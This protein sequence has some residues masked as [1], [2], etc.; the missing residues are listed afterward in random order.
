MLTEV[1]EVKGPT[2]SREAKNNLAKFRQ[3]IVTVSEL[4]E[5][6]VVNALL[7]EAY[8]APSEL[9]MVQAL[10][11]RLAEGVR[12]ARIDAGSIDLLTQ[13]F[14]LDS[15]E[16]IALMCLAEAML[17][18]PDTDTRNRLIR[19]K[20]V[21]GDWRAHVGKSPSMFVNATAWGLLFTGKMLK[22]PD[23]SVLLESLS[24]VLRKGGEAVVRAGVSFAMLMLGKQFVTGETIEEAIRVAQER[25]ARGYCYSY[26]MLGEAALTREDAQAYYDAYWHAIEEIGKSAKQQG[27]I[28]GHGVSVKLTGLHPRYEMSQRERVI[29]EMYP[30]LLKL[31]CAAKQWNIGFHLD[32]EDAARFDLTLEMLERLACAP[33]LKGWDGLGISLQAY[34]K[35]GRAVVDWVIGLARANECKILVRLVK[36]A[37]W[38]TEIKR[39]QIEGTKEFP[40]FTRKVYSDVSYI[41]CAKRL[42]AA[43]DAVFP[44]FATHNAF[45]IA[46]IHT[47]GGDKEYEFQCLHGM[48]ET[49]YDQVVGDGKLG[50]RC[51]IYAPV[52]PHETLLAYLVRRLLENGANSSFVS[53]IVNP[54]ISIADIVE[55]PVARAARTAGRPHPH[56]VSPP[57]LLPGRKNAV[58]I[59]LAGSADFDA[60]LADLRAHRIIAEPLIGDGRNQQG[61]AARLIPNPSDQAEMLGSVSESNLDTLDAALEIAVGTGRAWAAR[62]LAE[63][64]Q[65]VAAVG[66]LLEKNSAR[67]SALLVLE[68]GKTLPDAAEEVRQAIG[69][70]RL[71]AH[72]AQTNSSLLHA[73]PLGAVVAISPLSS[74]L[75]VFVGQV[76]VA[77]IAGNAVLAKPS[78]SAVLIAFESVRLFHQAGIPAPA[79][80][81]LPGE[82]R[83]VG[84][85]LVRDHRVAA[86]LFS[87]SQAISREIGAALAVLPHAPIFVA[88]TGGFNSMIVDSSAL[89]EQVISDAICSAFDSAGQRASSLRLLCLQDSTAE[90]VLGMLQGMLRERVVGAPWT[91]STDIGP[92]V[93]KK[94]QNGCEAYVKRMADKGFPVWRAAVGADSKNGRFVAPAIIDL[95]HFDAIQEI[96]QHVMGPVLHVV[97]WKSGQL[98][99]LLTW[100]NENTCVLVQ[101]LHTRIN[102]TAGYVLSATRADN[103]YINR[104]MHTAAVG[105]QP[106]G[107]VGFAGTGPK[108]AGPLALSRLVKQSATCW[109]VDD[110]AFGRTVQRPSD[111]FNEIPVISDGKKLVA[112]IVHE[113]RVVEGRMALLKVIHDAAIQHDR[114][115]ADGK[116]RIA[117]NLEKLRNVISSGNAFGLPAP[118][119]EENT[120][121]FL[122]KGRA[123][124]LGTSEEGVVQQVLAAVSF[125]NQVLLPRSPIADVLSAI[126]GSEHCILVENNI[127]VSAEKVGKSEPQVIL[128]DFSGDHLSAFRERVI[129]ACNEMV[130]VIVPDNEGAYDWT[131][132]V[133]ERTIAIN[134]S[135]AGGNTQLMM[136]TE[137]AT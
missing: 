28:M 101:G 105:M 133:R 19:D 76:A 117:H 50:R 78:S 83:V 12:E 22:P 56:I 123:L 70:C 92:V 46:A 35:C 44:Q 40:V 91:S 48:G 38:D 110:G 97:R 87:G 13:E 84:S 99:S 54:E 136:L 24:R 135:A 85:A 47:L 37:Y 90:K 102:E 74:P 129:V 94:I 107:G 11:T 36:G 17:R 7:K 131:Y 59:N 63:R 77:L 81:F 41:A 128:T 49:V 108:V 116:K 31:A 55:D 51:R 71:Y 66:D 45:S 62:S 65:K 10:A 118:A 1:F 88:A 25:E 43:Q 27:P 32:Q 67:L 132:L 2:T 61:G 126:L 82:G 4:E 89:P 15:R 121:E 127:A 72:Q 119:G 111:K 3:R 86:V 30:Q 115:R 34:Q 112:R 96:E 104:A 120:L 64:A 52:G 21:D 16:G 122:P 98:D 53:Q 29:A 80:Q 20:I 14:S 23:E 95:G 42:L 60:A 18:I 8:L 75:S 113:R 69:L 9:K 5:E 106:H 103:V 134:V 6:V 137:E 58:A 79:L 109:S 114:I 68:N 39:C 93:T 26:D 130:S 57:S 100:L 33:E 125:G 124:C 73:Q